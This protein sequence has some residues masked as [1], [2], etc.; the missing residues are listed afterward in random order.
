MHYARWQRHGDTA[1]T[2]R[3]RAEGSCSIEG[4]DNPQKARGWCDIHWKRWRKHG[5]PVLKPAARVVPAE[6][7][8]DGCE[9]VVKAAGLCGACYARQRRAANPAAPPQKRSCDICGTD[10][11]NRRK[12]AR[13][14]SR[15][16]RNAAR[17]RIE[18]PATRQ[19]TVI[20]D[21]TRCPSPATH[22]L[23]TDA[24]CKKHHTRYERHGDPLA[25]LAEQRPNGEVQEHLHQ[26]ANARTDDCILLPSSASGRLS[27]TYQGKPM[28]AARAVWTITHAAP[29]SRH[30]LHTCHRG[31]D[32]CI[33]IRHLYLGDHE[34]NMLDMVEAGR[35]SR[36]ENS[37]R[38]VLTEANVRE[39]RRR[40]RAGEATQ[41]A[42]S[43]E[44]GVH[45]STISNV[46]TGR[47]WGWLGG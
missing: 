14:C 37:A 2:Y 20:E 32:G 46:V 33:N 3:P 9:R 28:T 18:R 11:A 30:V 42:L 24:W 38:S 41:Q 27:V 17:Y 40:Y 1:T 23:K 44:F 12:D 10:M 43:A 5:D 15:E 19:C 26:A 39:I 29:G 45:P 31:D 36:G 47:N 16:C 4:C 7:S 35:S 13:L 34:R 25:V 8:N 21:G 6:C 22:R